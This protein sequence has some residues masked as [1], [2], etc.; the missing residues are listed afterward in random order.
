[1]LIPLVAL[2]AIGMTSP[3]QAAEERV[4]VPAAN[5]VGFGMG[6]GAMA[7]MAPAG[8]SWQLTVRTSDGTVTTPD[9][10]RFAGPTQVSV[11]SA[12]VADGTWSTVVA[13]PR[14]D[15][16]LHQLD[17]R[18][19]VETKLDRLSSAAPESAVAV[20]HGSFAFVRSGAR[21]GVYAAGRGR[22]IKRLTSSTS[23]WVATSGS[24]VAYVRGNA[25]VVQPAS[26][27]APKLVF[28][29]ASK[30]SSLVLL[31]HR[32]AWLERDTGRLVLSP[33][34]GTTPRT[35]AVGAKGTTRRQLSAGTDSFSMSALG[36][37]LVTYL[38]EEGVKRVA[39]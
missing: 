17:L 33:R 27:R 14:D 34:F 37:G 28:R 19:G 32:V 1:M 12:V 4:L 39:L 38:D 5:N 6:G 15:G 26:G 31:R 16:D 18:T 10:P 7:W 30:P 22:A 21:A 29:A 9:V 11:S 23:P 20:A 25:V 3:A 13:Y 36:D 8:G 35:Y 24:R 2:G